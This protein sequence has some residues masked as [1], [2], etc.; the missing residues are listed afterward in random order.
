M[1]VSQPPPVPNASD[2]LP[3]SHGH[4]CAACG[5]PLDEHDKFC[6]ACGS[7]QGP[8]PV[9]L[10]P[11]VADNQKHI[12]CDNCGA[13]IT[14][15]PQQRS[16]I[17]PFCDSTYVTEFTPQQTGRQAPEF[18]IGF[19]ITHEQADEKFKEWIG[20]GGL[21]RPGDLRTAM[22]ADRL[23]G[24]YLPFW[25]FS[26]LAHSGWSAQIGEHW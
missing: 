15:D 8:P 11:P 25:S 1:R 23:K 5:S 18:V 13:E 14:C 9:P 7:T 17:C 10:P 20:R 3:S 26:M 21:F 6:P 16:Y 12:R 19:T 2:A 22:I 4:A 24:V